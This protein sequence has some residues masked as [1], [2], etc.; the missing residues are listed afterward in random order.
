MLVS[1]HGAKRH[2]AMFNSAPINCT[3]TRNF[4]MTAGLPATTAKG[5]TS[6]TTTAD[7][8]TIAPSPMVTPGRM[9]VAVAD[10]DVVAD[11][12]S[13]QHG[14][15]NALW[16]GWAEVMVVARPIESVAYFE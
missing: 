11:N 2:Q 8:P 16:N 15:L 3:G 9:K 6:F 10:I 5:G 12:S 4:L 14:R 7:A 13:L 1:C